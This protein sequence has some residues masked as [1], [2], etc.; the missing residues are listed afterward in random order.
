MTRLKG[1]GA[2]SCGGVAQ[3]REE[4]LRALGCQRWPP[5]GAHVASSSQGRDVS[6]FRS[7]DH[8]KFYVV[9]LKNVYTLLVVPVRNPASFKSPIH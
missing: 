5:G 6:R 2:L 3:A 7:L 9:T 4:R 1:Q 8:L